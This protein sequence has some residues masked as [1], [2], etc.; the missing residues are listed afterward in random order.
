MDDGYPDPDRVV[1]AT[2]RPRGRAAAVGWVERVET[3]AARLIGETRRFEEWD[4]AF[5][6]PSR[7]GPAS[8]AYAG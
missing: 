4:E 6:R 1:D 2:R 8:E 3:V 7:I 5:G